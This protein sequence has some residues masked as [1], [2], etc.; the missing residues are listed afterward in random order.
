MATGLAA[1]G[2]RSAD[3]TA[4]VQIRAPDGPALSASA[5]IPRVADAGASAPPLA[6]GKE[7]PSE[8]GADAGATSPVPLGTGQLLVVRSSGWSAVRA[9][10]RRY[11]RAAHGWQ[12]VGTSIPVNVGR[13]GMAWGRGLQAEDPSLLPKKKEGDAK[14]PAG[15][16][17]LGSAFGY[18]DKPA[19]NENAYPYVY[20]HPRMSCIE[21]VRSPYY[22]QVIDVTESPGVRREFRSD[23]RRPDGLFRTGLIVK[24]NAEQTSGA[25]SCVFMHVWRGPGIGTAGC[26]AMASATI[27]QLVDW[28]D[29][30]QKPVLVQ[31]P[32]S[33]Y[34]RLKDTWRLPD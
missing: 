20:L 6:R 27:Q 29:P 33:E 8:A 23:M 17:A 19:A 2:S 9:T 30:Q 28:L 12:E 31:L 13:H 15:V 26:T 7:Q 21:D 1:L 24:Q 32:E 4:P 16:F 18:D 11:L 3:A 5:L 14:A 34:Q 25:G 22:N 10:L